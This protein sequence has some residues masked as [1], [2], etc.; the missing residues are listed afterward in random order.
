MSKKSDL[1]WEKYEEEDYLDSKHTPYIKKQLKYFVKEVLKN[2]PK[3]NAY[4]YINYKLGELANS[5]GLDNYDP[6]YQIRPAL[7]EMLDK[8]VSKDSILDLIRV[9][10]AD[11]IFNLLQVIQGQW[12][13][14]GNWGFYFEKDGEP[15]YKVGEDELS[16]MFYYPEF[17]PRDKK[18]QYIKEYNENQERIKKRLQKKGLI[19]K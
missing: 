6:G 15:I 11:A 19:K 14:R 16:H 2:V 1:I 12:L 3:E 8:N 9:A 4:S 10:Q 7:Q 5:V 13:T 18:K 17:V